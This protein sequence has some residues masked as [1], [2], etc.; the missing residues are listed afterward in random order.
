MTPGVAERAPCTWGAFLRHNIL[1]KKGRI[2]KKYSPTRL[3]EYLAEGYLSVSR[4]LKEEN[5]LQRY[6]VSKTGDKFPLQLYEEGIVTLHC[7]NKYFYS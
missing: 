3:V 6:R 5:N 7:P 2:R 4:A 1:S